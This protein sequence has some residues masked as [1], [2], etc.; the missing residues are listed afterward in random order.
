MARRPTGP[1]R[2]E[3]V[4]EDAGRQGHED[5]ARTE[6]RG[7]E[8]ILP[9]ERDEDEQD[10]AD[11][12]QAVEGSLY[13]DAGRHAAPADPGAPPQLVG[14]VDLAGPGRKDVVGHVSDKDRG[15]QLPQREHPLHP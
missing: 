9:R 3:A 6:G 13:H 7:A 12:H 15:H 14:P 2:F 11:Q 4:E 5:Q 8:V 1:I 10:H